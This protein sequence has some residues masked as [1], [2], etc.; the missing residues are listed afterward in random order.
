MGN[1][2]NLKDLLK[3]AEKE[4][5][6]ILSLRSS[7]G[8]LR[9][10]ASV[11]VGENR[12]AIDKSPD[13]TFLQAY[14]CDSAGSPKP[15]W[16][17]RARKQ[18]YK[19]D[20]VL[21]HYVHYSTVTKGLLDT[22]EEAQKGNK[23]WERHFGES[24]PSERNA[25]ELAEVVMVHAKTTESVT[26]RGFSKKCRYDYEKKWQGCFVAYPWPS[27]STNTNEKNAHDKD[28]MEY[29]CWINDRVEDYYV[30]KLR[31][32]LAQRASSG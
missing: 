15:S 21:Y 14:N 29:N 28:G 32:A 24:P 3:D 22:Y 5:T 17:D 23:T 26:T 12:L 16:A 6:N 4:G 18:I 25:D 2:T 30:P 27:N 31:E 1:Y 9:K 11:E 8:R 20:Y 19:T 7:R 13:A 10:D